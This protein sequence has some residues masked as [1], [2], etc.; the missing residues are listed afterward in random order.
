MD[1]EQ[2]KMILE[3][4]G[5]ATGAAATIGKWLVAR[6]F[7]DMIIG[8]AVGFTALTMLYK[9]VSHAVKSIRDNCFSHKLREIVL[10]G[11]SGD[12]YESEKTAIINVIKK[13]LEK[14]N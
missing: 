2:L 4:I 12:I 10:P 1:L 9:C 14:E 8:Y 6:M 7:I 11:A 5:A 13:G 3:T